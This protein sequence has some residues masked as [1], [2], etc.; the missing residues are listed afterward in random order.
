MTLMDRRTFLA[1]GAAGMITAAAVDRLMAPHRRSRRGRGC[2]LRLRAAAAHARPARP[3]RP[4]AA[5]GLLVRHVRRHRLADVRRQPDAARA[6]RHGGVPRPARD[7]AA[8]PQPRGPQR[9]RD[10]AASAADRR[11]RSTTRRPAA[12]RRR[13]TTTRAPAR[14]CAASCRSTARRSTA[15]AAS[16]SPPQ[17]ADA[18]RRRSAARTTPIRP[19]VL[20]AARLPV[21][22]AASTAA[23]GALPL[24]DAAARDGPLLARGRRRPTSAPASCTRPRI[25]A[26]GAARA[27]TASCPR[28]P[29]DLAAGGRLQILASAA[30][31][32][33]T[34]ARARQPG[35]GCR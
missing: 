32:S 1:R 9:R 19:A 27:S 4:R 35:G 30:S 6:R 34:R 18:A 16:A 12:A 28:I 20:Q 31:R 7:R 8:D 11:R 10:A 33:T 17:L 23:P 21:R 15:P 3:L 25:P 13:W 29:R 24:G 5:G 26:A 14:S 22:G 2:R